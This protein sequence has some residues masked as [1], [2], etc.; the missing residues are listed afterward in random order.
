VKKSQGNGVFLSIAALVLFS[1][2]SS[3]GASVA[4]YYLERG[5]EEK[6]VYCQVVVSVSSSLVFSSCFKFSVRKKGGPGMRKE[7]IPRKWLVMDVAG[8]QGVG[9]VL[10]AACTHVQANSAFGRSSD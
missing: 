7:K 6:L 4:G 5:G 8:Q 3:Y 2:F 1:F 10:F 9:L